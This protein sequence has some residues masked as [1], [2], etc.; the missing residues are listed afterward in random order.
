LSH[1]PTRES[2]N[3]PESNEAR[4]SFHVT[5]GSFT[6]GFFFRTFI[7]YTHNACVLC[8][9][10]SI[11]KRIKNT[12]RIIVRAAGVVF[13]S[14]PPAHFYNVIPIIRVCV[15]HDYVRCTLFEF[16]VYFSIFSHRIYGLLFTNLRRYLL[17][18]WDWCRRL[19]CAK[20]RYFNHYDVN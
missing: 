18:R 8:K 13:F 19:S 1:G 5:N 14:P 12:D 2:N 7:I 3:L 9:S 10:Y 17:S 20:T 16:W 11:Q 6:I 4:S 15:R